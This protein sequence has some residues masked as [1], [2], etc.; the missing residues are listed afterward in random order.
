M[1]CGDLHVLCIFSAVF[2]TLKGVHGLE[3]APPRVKRPLSNPCI[4]LLRTGSSASSG[5]DFVETL[6]LSAEEGMIILHS[7]RLN[8]TIT[9]FLKNL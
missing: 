4:H 1:L 7:P 8:H 2:L 5:W 6:P 9:L 3:C